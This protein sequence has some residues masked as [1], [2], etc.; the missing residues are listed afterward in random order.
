MGRIQELMKLRQILHPNNQR[1]NDMCQDKP[2]HADDY[3][4]ELQDGDIIVS[5]TDGVFDNLFSYEIYKCVKNFRLKHTRLHTREQ[6]E[7][8]AEIIV[9]E[10]LE[11]V[12]DKRTKTPFQRK[13]KK[14]Y[15]ATWEGGKEDDITAVVTFAVSKY[16][17][18]SVNIPKGL[19]GSTSDRYN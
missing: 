13:Y 3:E 19:G 18:T 2:E 8:L 10:S 1:R 14:Q 17:P 4:E 7:Q 16:G 5:A 9:R 11:K 15:N 6:A 12:N